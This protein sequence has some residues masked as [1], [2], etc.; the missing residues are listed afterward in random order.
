MSKLIKFLFLVFILTEMPVAGQDFLVGGKVGIGKAT[1][2]NQNTDERV[3][4]TISRYGLSLGFSP[5]FSK[6]FIQSGAEIETSSLGSFMT[7]PLTI[8][9]AVGEKVRPYVDLGG[10]YSFSTR[11]KQD[12]FLVQNN[13]GLKAGLGMLYLL[14][15]RWRIEA[16]LAF[17]YGLS[18][19]FEEEI[20]LPGNQSVFDPYLERSLS[21]ELG[22]AYRF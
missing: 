21:F 5:Y 22:M 1:F 4:E 10:Y 20:L 6:L 12:E 17:R 2:R 9:V 15:K 3:D 11:S 19:T 8:R 16:G 13:G 14:D 18:P 7:V